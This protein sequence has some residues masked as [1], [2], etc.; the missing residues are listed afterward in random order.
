MFFDRK[1]FFLLLPFISFLN[2]TNIKVHNETLQPIFIR[3]YYT[4]HQ[5]ATKISDIKVIEPSNKI[6][7]KRPKRKFRYDR[8]L[9][10]SYKK[11]D[12]K[13]NIEGANYLNTPHHGIGILQGKSFYIAPEGSALVCY[14]LINW[15]VIQKSKKFLK[16][17]FGEILKHFSKIKIGD[18]REAHVRVS[19][20]LPKQEIDYLDKRKSITKSA[21]ETIVGQNIADEHLP[22]I[23]VCLS[24]GG[25][26]AMLATLGLFMGLE[27]SELLDTITYIAGLSGSTWFISPWLYFNESVAKYKI[28]LKPKVKIGLGKKKNKKGKIKLDFPLKEFINY[29]VLKNKIF[30]QKLT[31]VDIYGNLLADKLFSDLKRPLRNKV[32]LSQLGL[33]IQDGKKPFPI[34]T[35]IKPG[36]PSTWF[37]FTPYEIGPSLKNSFVPTWSFG[38]KFLSGKSKDKDVEG[39]LG[40]YMGIWGSAYTATLQVLFSEMGDKLPNELSKWI[41]STLVLFGGTNKRISPAKLD[42]PN[43]GLRN[44]SFKNMKELILIDAGLDYNLPFPPLLRPERKVDII[45]VC[46]ASANAHKGAPAI[47]SAEKWAKEKGI[48]FPKIDYNLIGKD[49]YSI[50]KD[51]NDLNVPTIIYFSLVKNNEFNSNFDPIKEIKDGFCNTFNFVYES[52]QFEMLTGLTEY[53]FMKAEKIVKQEIKNKVAMKKGNLRQIQNEQIRRQNEI[54]KRRR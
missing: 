12:L 8:M 2:A 52:D 38:R 25:Y 33:N 45:I 47:R 29:S 7:F 18:K 53:N 5:K 24:G 36:P 49:I 6:I 50:F 16:N 9:L 10:F 17:Y 27:K 30:H 51:E 28:R 1:L 46:D 31:S 22:N 13:D 48:K 43:Y 15:N 21:I 37:E 34:L 32:K 41:D 26:R 39:S 11:D 19:K 20:E 3:T 35:A 4:K 54:N 23:A 40:F 42:N 44:V 14:K